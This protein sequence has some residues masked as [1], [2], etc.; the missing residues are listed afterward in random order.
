MNGIILFE[1][2]YAY[3]K[4]LLAKEVYKKSLE[5]I[6]IK[7]QQL[8]SKNI[9]YFFRTSNTD[10]LSRNKVVKELKENGDKLFNLLAFEK[11]NSKINFFVDINSDIQYR[12]NDVFYAEGN[13]I[14]NF[15]NAILRGDLIK[16]DLENKL[17]TVVGNVIFKKGEQY[18]E[19]QNFILI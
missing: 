17:L 19:A 18:F 7:Y 1:F 5:E 13:A 9:D 14:I 10:Y 15:S 6:N 4:S 3:P 16:Y 11:S 8:K 2:C 12:E